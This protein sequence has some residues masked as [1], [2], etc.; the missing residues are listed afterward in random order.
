[1]RLFRLLLSCEKFILS[2]CTVYGYRKLSVLKK[3]AWKWAK[4]VKKLTLKE[5]WEMLTE[6]SETVIKWTDY[7][8]GI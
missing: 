7:E 5:V 3:E 1:M 4:D 2:K 8:M 6:R